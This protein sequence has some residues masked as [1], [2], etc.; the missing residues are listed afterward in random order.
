MKGR[1]YHADYRVTQQRLAQFQ[2]LCYIYA[3]DNTD[4]IKQISSR[5]GWDSNLHRP[6]VFVEFT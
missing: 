5:L 3:L 6:L 2:E 1:V 4:E